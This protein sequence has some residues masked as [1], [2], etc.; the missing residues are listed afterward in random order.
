MLS[1]AQD[2]YKHVTTELLN[3]VKHL[4]GRHVL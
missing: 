4:F 3:I 2:Q 1:T